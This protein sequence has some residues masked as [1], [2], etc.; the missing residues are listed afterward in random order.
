MSERPTDRPIA[1]T[2]DDRPPRGTDVPWVDIH[3]HTQTLTWRDREKF[4]LSGGQ[5]VV[6]IAAAY[7]WS[8]YRP[9]SPSDVRFL[10]DNALRRARCFDARHFYDQYLA[11]AVHT[12]AS[13]AETEELLSA[14][15]DYCA[16]DEVVAIG[17]TGIESTHHTTGWSIEEQRQVVREQAHI[18]RETDIPIL[19]HTPGSNKDGLPAR[20]RH[21]YEEAP[22]SFTDHLLDPETAK[23][24]AT[25]IDIDLVDEAGLP[26]EQVV[27]DHADGTI[28]PYVLENTNCYLAFSISSPWLRGVD[29][30]DVAEAIDEYGPDRIIMDTD[31]MG[32][33]QYDPFALKR[34]TFDLFRLGISREDVQKVVYENPQEALGLDLEA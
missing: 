34:A 17:E 33:K 5:A 25:E 3:Q 32:A 15:P 24:E 4:D 30:R 10:W 1:A 29:A 19:F 18:A 12:W 22:D 27:I 7:Y 2:P 23:M 14:L 31:L 13:V 6:M 21:D 8:P 16:C 11:V 20:R 9:V 28:T 26:D